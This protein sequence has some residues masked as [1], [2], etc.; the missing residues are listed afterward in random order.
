MLRR[1]LCFIS[2]IFVFLLTTENSKEQC[3]RLYSTPLFFDKEEANER[4]RGSE[5]VQ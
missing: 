3:H 2:F 1:F 5:G 4:I